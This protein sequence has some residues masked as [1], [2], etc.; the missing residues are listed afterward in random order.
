MKFKFPLLKTQGLSPLHSQSPIGFTKELRI[1]LE[2]LTHERNCLRT[3]MTWICW[4]AR[5]RWLQDFM[6]LQNTWQGWW[7]HPPNMIYILKTYMLKVDQYFGLIRM[8]DH[9]IPKGIIDHKWTHPRWRHAQRMPLPPRSVHQFQDRPL[10]VRPPV[11]TMTYQGPT[12]RFNPV[13]VGPTFTQTR[14][15][16]SPLHEI[17]SISYFMDPHMRQYPRVVQP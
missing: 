16:V 9:L 13:L 6:V 17:P 8:Q 2:G 7:Y 15:T 5:T 14:L 4:L 1:S 3:Q 12:P 10:M 11:T